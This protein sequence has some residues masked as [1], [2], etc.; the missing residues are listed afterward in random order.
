MDIASPAPVQ[1]AVEIEPCMETR[2]LNRMQ[3]TAA[4]P[5]EQANRG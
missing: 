3:G 2:E 1:R 4:V 5:T